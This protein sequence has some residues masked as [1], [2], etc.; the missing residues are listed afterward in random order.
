MKVKLKI[1]SIPVPQ[2]LYDFS[3]IKAT[4]NV[5]DQII[6]DC[7][8]Y[9][10]KYH[11]RSE[12]MKYID[13]TIIF[14]ICESLIEILL[15]LLRFHDELRIKGNDAKDFYEYVYGKYIKKGF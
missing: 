8:A 6:R 5:P 7:F 2:N 9:T 1:I 10:K 14:G 4:N 13:V 3:D 15:F 11:P 12:T